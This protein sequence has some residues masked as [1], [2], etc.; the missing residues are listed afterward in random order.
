MKRI[1]INATQ[2]EEIRVAL[3]TGNHLYDF[4]LENRTREQKKSNI[5][6]GHV[7][8]V[9]PSLEAVFV[10]YG[11]QRQGFLP[12][13]EISSEYLSGNPRDEN[14]K[15]LIKEGDE[16]I[17]QVE[18][19]ERGNKGA[20]LST[21]VSLAGRYLVLM[22]NNPRGGGISRQI[23]G[24]LRED[25]KR[26]LS[27][28]D[29]AKGMSVIIRT[30]GIGKTQEDLQH[31]LNHLLNIWQA[32]QEQ[33][34]K[35]PSPR[36]VHQEAGVVTRA[37][38]DY[39]RD[40]IAEIWIDNENAY[41]E[42]A[43]FIDAVMPKQAEKLRKYTDYEPM[44]S[45]FN[46]EKQ[47]ETAYQREVRLPSGGSIVID[48]TEALV[49][50][51]INSAKSTKGS[52]VAETA[53]HTNLEA[54]DEIARQLRLRDM[55][56]L[57][58]I[59]F[60]DMNDNKHQKE[61]EKRLI[62]ATKYDRARV[63]FGDISKFG[64]MEMSRQR[65]RPSLEESTG[66]I[67]PRCHGN[68]M[69][70]DLRSLSLSIMRQIE[71]IAL[72]ERQGEVQAEVPTD[73][74]AFLLNEKRDALV[75][76]EQDSGT[77]I[78]IL[79]H[80]HLESPNFKLHFNRDGFAP[81]SY[82]R[83]T[84]TA[85][86]H[87]DLGYDVD[88]QTADSAR[89]EQQPTR[90]PLKAIADKSTRS[91][92]QQDNKNSSRNSNTV[93]HSNEHRN[94]NNTN[95]SNAAPNQAQSNVANGIQQSNAPQNQAQQN[96]TQS[97]VITAK[98]QAV[99]WLSNLFAQAPQAQT[100]HSVSSTD[101]AEAIEALVNTGAT[102]LGSFGQVDSSAL[103]NTPSSPTQQDSRQNSQQR[104]EQ[105]S[106]NSTHRQQNN[107]SND[108][109]T[110]ENNDD[111]RKRNA[112]K[113]RSPK[114]R[115]RRE[116]RDGH[117]TQDSRSTSD[118]VDN[119]N[120]DA[121]SNANNVTDA[122]S[123]D[124]RNQRSDESRNDHRR[125]NERSRQD[126]TQ[127]DNPSET[128]NESNTA[129][130][131][132]ARSKR[133]PHSQRSSRGML[134]RNET[135]TGSNAKQNDSQTASN[136]KRADAR[137]NQNP[138][139]VV[140]QINE[141]PVKLK[142]PEIVHLSLDDSKAAKIEHKPAQPQMPESE[143]VD[144]EKVADAPKDSA[145]STATKTS[146]TTQSQPQSKS[147]KDEIADS[148]EKAVSEAAEVA[149][150][151]TVSISASEQAPIIEAGADSKSNL[152]QA[153]AVVS[154]VDNS[155]PKA[156]A[157]D[158]ALT[159]EVLFAKRYITA[160]KFGQA[161]NDP[162]VVRA[163]Q[164]QSLESQAPESETSAKQTVKSVSA[165]RGTVGEFI[166]ATLAKAQTR[167]EE[168]G[169]INCFIAAMAE[170]NSQSKPAMTAATADSESA[171]TDFDFSNYGYQP[172]DADYL[173]RF[174][175]MTTAVSQFAADQGKTSV[176]PSAITQR[177]SNDPR[178]QHPDFE[179]DQQQLQGDAAAGDTQENSIDA[180]DAHK[181]VATALTGAA[182]AAEISAE[183]EQLL[184]ADAQLKAESAQLLDEGFLTVEGS[185]PAEGSSTAEGSLPAES[186]LLESEALA[187]EDSQGN[188]SKTTIASYKN[189]IENVA[190]QL[191]PQTGMFNLTTAKVPKARSR[192]PKT[193]H[194]KP[195]Q[196]EK[197]ETD[198]TDTD[199]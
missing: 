156:E 26:M 72:K 193:E 64:L 124:N 103:V 46:I 171:G 157:I 145:A 45:R 160:A 140:L 153:D 137:D 165:I 43:G 111:K 173:S 131:K 47:I 110:D 25:M 120:N 122:K 172:L 139:E 155:A 14:I 20:A 195:T 35:Y 185:L 7:T 71:Q 105:A 121:H 89:P 3:C 174:K 42:A 170:H 108:H 92:N 1:L 179:Q 51:D 187:K 11:S 16:L 66:Y 80:A 118:N 142:S 162:R 130:D 150:V 12:I 75:Y 134:E 30:A 62:D 112:R 10:E 50:I 114:P 180:V 154:E 127:N 151:D 52:D 128:S 34:Q 57:I 146:S 73:I 24:K 9:E 65:L 85:Q 194:K 28:L 48:Q 196:A 53:Y 29:L 181:V 17:V 93:T 31:D 5:Y 4:D 144:V 96:N 182:Q 6:K 54:A 136:N 167:M 19:E 68:G 13:R 106:D 147:S 123:S 60:I 2:N 84:D 38:R 39:L 8:R 90:Q 161:S 37:V 176:T 94:H 102:S 55:G 63:Q 79:P 18:K 166:Q 100:A 158:T 27:N 82:E 199:S 36:L 69:I 33:N 198:D 186:F 61:V 41:I 56:G 101:A 175:I 177:A 99:A 183:S 15:K 141:A 116:Q 148:H 97:P 115:Q 98:P 21:Y 86:E 58:V 77:R 135:L 125:Q 168:D 191:L 188:K 49:S 81:S 197:A 32:I 178:G 133:K 74:A 152:K 40:D 70:R 104:N 159:S 95:D 143:T 83:I 149:T 190:E 169:V 109:D 67:C 189:M 107:R 119:S 192:K 22:P 78:T 164:A 163:Q 129:A 23:S 126:S 184:E 132:Q 91:N 59:D 88:W 87:S 44:F 117:E 113:S 138:N 76:L